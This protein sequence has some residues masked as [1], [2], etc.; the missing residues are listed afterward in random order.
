MKEL[1][2]H[3]DNNIVIMLVGNKSDL[4]HLRAVPTDE[5][6]AFSGQFVTTLELHSVSNVY[7]AEIFLY[8]SMIPKRFAQFE[9]SINVL[10]SSYRFI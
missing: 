7:N 8:K 4:R 3:A 9:I 5:A 2:D 1:R 10:V 6:K